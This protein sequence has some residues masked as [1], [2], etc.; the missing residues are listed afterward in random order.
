M[1]A[2]IFED[3]DA[4]AAALPPAGR[5]LGIDLGSKTIG[6]AVTDPARTIAT[7]VD[8]LARGKF[9]NDAAT[10]H[11]IMEREGVVAIV[12]GLPLNMDGSSGSR[13]QATRAYARNLLARLPRPVL[14]WDE[15]LTTIAAERMLIE[16]DA[17]RARRRSVI[18]KLA[19]TLILQ[20]ATDR[21]RAN[22]LTSDLK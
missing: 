6:L 8:T 16:A 17:S 9:S 18:D 11:E 15:R 5:L 7:P 19:A 4:F 1:A 3:A 21:L 2:E 10:L 14:L 22:G 20:N 13:V 12:I